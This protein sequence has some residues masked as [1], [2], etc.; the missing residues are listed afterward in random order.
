MMTQAPPIDADA[1]KLRDHF[2]SMPA[3]SLTAP[4]A[5]RLVD[6]RPEHASEMLSILEDE[7]FLMHDGAGRFR[8][9]EPCLA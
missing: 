8:R 4:Q 2:F 5:A 9:T 6:V 1:L 3:L 7:G